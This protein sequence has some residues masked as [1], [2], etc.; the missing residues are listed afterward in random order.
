MSL[1]CKSLRKLSLLIILATFWIS[2]SLKGQAPTSFPVTGEISMGKGPLSGANV[3]IY[4]GSKLVQNLYTDANGEYNCVLPLNAEYLVVVEKAGLISKRYT[5][6]ATGVPP[7]RTLP[8]EGID[9]SM[10][11]FEKM[12]GVDYS[13]FN[14]PMNKFFYD[15]KADNFLYDK[16][17]LEQMLS[18]AERVKEQEKALKNKAKEAENNYQNAI[19][20]GDKALSK[21]EYAAAL[22]SYQQALG[23]KANEPYP[24]DQINQV[25]QLMDEE[26]AAKAKAEAEAKAKAEAEAAAKKKAEEE[27]AAKAKA[28]AEAKAKAEAE[29]AAKKKAEEEAAAKAKAEAEAKAKAEAEAAAKK[30]AEEEAAAKAKAEADAKAKA[31][32]EAAAKKKA[33]E[34][35]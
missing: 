2:I 7:E 28:E 14:Q 16:P 30:K 26:A 29:A 12:D 5:I 1:F 25:K 3:K 27:A 35:A 8:F 24:K 32:A 6:T 18:A 20:A 10:T 4:Q 11:L 21:K 15:T 17:Y 23:I 9:A 31:E 22:T 33:E 19:K 13:L 34:E